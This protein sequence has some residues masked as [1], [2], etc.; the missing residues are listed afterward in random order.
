MLIKRFGTS[1]VLGIAMV[2]WSIIT[3]CTGFIQNYTQAIV[4][5]LLL[6]LFEAGL[7]PGVTFMMSMYSPWD[8]DDVLNHCQV[9]SGQE[10]LRA[11]ALP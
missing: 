11:S 1:V 3:M 6:G 2:S 4:V 9:L 8:L 7:V 5:R 10:S